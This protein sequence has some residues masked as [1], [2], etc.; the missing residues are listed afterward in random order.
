M[1]HYPEHAKKFFQRAK[2][3]SNKNIEVRIAMT[4]LDLYVKM[5]FDA[6]PSAHILQGWWDIDAWKLSGRK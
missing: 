6:I 1:R 2:R 5:I 4:M 3:I